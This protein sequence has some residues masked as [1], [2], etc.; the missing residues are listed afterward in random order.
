MIASLLLATSSLATP[1]LRSR[2]VT[3]DPDDGLNFEEICGSHDNLNTFEKARDAWEKTT[4]AYHL[5]TYITSKMGGNAD[6]WMNDM[7]QWTFSENGGTSA[8]DDCGTLGG[9][10]VQL[11]CNEFFDRNRSYYYWV[12]QGVKG[13]HSQYTTINRGITEETVKNALRIGQISDDFSKPPADRSYAPYLSAAFNMGAGLAVKSNP[14]A[15]V[16]TVFTGVFAAVGSS[17]DSA[18]FVDPDEVEQTLLN[19]FE[20]V[21]D[22]LD[23]NL[24]LATGNVPDGD[25][26]SLPNSE[27]TWDT[28]VANCKCCI[29]H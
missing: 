2:Q 4:A 8:M 19:I 28:P 23:N 16:L 9:C 6:N 26:A 5:D 11:K 12:L 18:S 13:L 3:T 29:V 1:V 21:T 27:G 24:R 25:Y 10:G 7:Y 20:A 14:A 15:G 17:E 22:R